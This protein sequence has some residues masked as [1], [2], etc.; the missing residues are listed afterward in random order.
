MI[1]LRSSA[2]VIAIASNGF[3]PPTTPLNLTVGVFPPVVIVKALAAEA[4]LFTVEP[5]II[6]SPAVLD[7]VVQVLL[8]PLTVTAPV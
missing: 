4:S 1:A 2:P 7:V 8:P 5:K 6:V 3:V